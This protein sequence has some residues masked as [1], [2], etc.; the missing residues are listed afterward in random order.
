MP[1]FMASSSSSSN[2][3]K[4]GRDECEKDSEGEEED[5]SVSRSIDERITRKKTHRSAQIDGTARTPRRLSKTKVRRTPPA[6]K[7]CSSRRATSWKL[8]RWE[9]RKKGVQKLDPTA[10]QSRQ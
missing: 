2:C 7:R 5:Q 10:D 8:S 3:S 4:D 6:T 9:R 1:S